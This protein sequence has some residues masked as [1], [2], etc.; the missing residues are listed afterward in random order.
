MSVF[1]NQSVKRGHSHGI[2]IGI[3]LF[4]LAGIVIAYLLVSAATNRKINEKRAETQD[5]VNLRSAYA[6]ALA[7]ASEGTQ[8][9]VSSEVAVHQKEPGWQY[10]VPIAGYYHPDLE[11]AVEELSHL[12]GGKYTIEI[13][14]DEDNTQ[15]VVLNAVE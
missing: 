14:I 6:E 4:V 13:M 9:A 10:V 1:K 11:D 2:M 3:I 15:R 8:R 5:Y 7:K 12:I